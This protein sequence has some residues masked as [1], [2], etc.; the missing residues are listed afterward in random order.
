MTALCDECNK[1][2]KFTIKCHCDKWLCPKCTL[3]RRDHEHWDILKKLHNLDSD[4]EIDRLIEEE[5]KK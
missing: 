2:V 4:P 5:L 3:T 1:T